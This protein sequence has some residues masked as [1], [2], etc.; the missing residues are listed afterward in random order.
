MTVHYTWRAE[1]ALE[2][3]AA[4]TLETWGEAQRERYMALLE[5]ACEVQVPTL[6]QQMMERQESM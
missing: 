4:Y 1:Q 6:W 5:H 2:E 3:I